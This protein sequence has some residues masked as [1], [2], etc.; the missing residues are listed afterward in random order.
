MHIAPL[1]MPSPDFHRLQ[2]TSC[3]HATAQHEPFSTN[4]GVLQETAGLEQGF[5][6]EGC[7]SGAGQ[8]SPGGFKRRRAKQQIVEKAWALACERVSSKTSESLTLY[9][10]PLHKSA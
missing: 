2:Q 8:H 3:W 7:S 9:N 5:P 1:V 6:S 4:L 10:K